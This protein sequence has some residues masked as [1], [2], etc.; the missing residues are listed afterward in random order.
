ML[1]EEVTENVVELVEN[2]NFAEKVDRSLELT[3]NQY[4]RQRS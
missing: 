3:A 2:L 1:I 4:R